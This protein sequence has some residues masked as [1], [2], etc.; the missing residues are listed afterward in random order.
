MAKNLDEH[1]CVR[2]LPAD[3]LTREIL[4]SAD[5]AQDDTRMEG[6][7]RTDNLRGFSGSQ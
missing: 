6:G 7:K 3:A 1:S 5:C 4:R 2:R